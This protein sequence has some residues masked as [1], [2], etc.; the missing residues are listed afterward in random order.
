M[1]NAVATLPPVDA[2]AEALD[3]LPS[4]QRLAVLLL[5]LGSRNADV[6]RETGFRPETISRLRARYRERMERVQRIRD[7]R[8]LEQRNAAFLAGLVELRDTEGLTTLARLLRCDNYAAAARAVEILLGR[9][10]FPASAEL[11]HEVTTQVDYLSTPAMRRIL[12]AIDAGE[13]T[14]LDVGPPD[15]LQGDSA[16]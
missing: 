13:V 14:V 8:M 2:V 4:R 6:A 10:G 15:E 9:T 7:S 11:R 16:N 1:S 12:A 3:G 5:A